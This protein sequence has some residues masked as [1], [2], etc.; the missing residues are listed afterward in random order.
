MTD[1]PQLKIE[2]LHERH[3]GLTRALADSYA[4]AACVCWSRHHQPPLTVTLKHKNGDERR[5]VNFAPPDARMQRAH[6]NEI[7]ATETGAYGVALAAVEVVTGLVTVGRAETLTGADWY[8]APNGT[9][10]EDFEN[11]VRLEVSGINAGGSTEIS[12]RLSE[13]TAQ[14]VRG[15]SNLPAM[16]SVVGFKALEVAISSLV[17]Q[18]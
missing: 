18:S 9:A 1:L 17:A 16:A 8:I 5:V 4:E 12:R 3:P 10:I 13:K 14:A 15:K 6:A 2:G 11:C 7:D